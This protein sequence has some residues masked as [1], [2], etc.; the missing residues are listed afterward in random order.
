M[1]KRVKTKAD[2]N[3][4]ALSS[5]ASVSNQAGQKFNSS[6]MVAK[7]TKRL[8]PDPE[9]K[10]IPKTPKPEPKPEPPVADPGSVLVAE[11]IEAAAKGNA[12]MIA[13]LKK[14][15]SEIKF[16]E[17]RPLLEWNFDMIRDDKGYLIRIKAC[18]AEPVKR[19]LN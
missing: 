1:K 19:T 2:L 17:D 6:N 9:A 7:P 18:C 13:E 12:M 16:S 3:S 14:Q 15:I 11:K 8:E 10:Q 5:G 4:M